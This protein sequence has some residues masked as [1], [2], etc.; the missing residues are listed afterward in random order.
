MT[1][2]TRSR[3]V[4]APRGIAALVVALAA[5]VAL[6]AGPPP[7][8]PPGPVRTIDPPSPRMV[9]RDARHEASGTLVRAGR[10]RVWEDRAARAG[11]VLELGVLVLPALDPP[12]RPDPVFVLAGGPGQDATSLVNQW[13]EHWMRRDRDIVLV[14]QRGTGGDNRLACALAGS[15]ENLQGY[16]DPLMD[17]ETFRAC[18]AELQERYD[19]TQYGTATAMDDIDEVRAAL[20]YERINVYGGSYGSRAA[21]ELLRRHGDS[22]RCVVLNSVAPT[23]FRNPLYHARSAQEALDLIVEECAGDPAC[24]ATFGNLRAKFETV[25]ERLEAAP[26]PVTVRHPA[27][28]EAVALRLTR[29]AFAESMRIAMYYDSRRVPRLIHRAFSGDLDAVAQ[30]GLE[31][32]RALRSTLA[33]GMLLCVTCG[34]DLDRIDPAE[35]AAATRGTFLGDDR[36]RRQMAVCAFWPRSRNLE[37]A[38]EPVRSDVPVLLMSGTMDPVTPP[39]WGEAAARHLSRS[40]HVVAPGSHGLGG[41]CIEG[42]VRAFLDAGGPEGLDL[43]CVESLRPGSFVAP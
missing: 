10:F 27:T 19:L 31:T 36:V 32:S 15:D 5:G 26:A 38:G 7:H 12:A 6:R 9:L 24:R 34:E 37:G 29:E 28:G 11:R 33:L 18:L 25:L 20:G 39:R 16:L 2:R 3:S 35:I 40:V 4:N 17:E 42:I 8:R 1:P 23:A 21:L 41:P 13:V 22:V 14:S 30:V 43:S